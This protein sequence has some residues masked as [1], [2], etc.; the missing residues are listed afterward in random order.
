MSLAI[1]AE[2]NARLL[3]DLRDRLGAK[4]F[5][6]ISNFFEVGVNW[7]CP[8]C[9]RSKPEI[10]RLD[11][12]SDLL[13]S[14][15]LHHDHFD[16]CVC[17]H[18]DLR[19]VADWSVPRAIEESLV[20]FSAT[21]IC[22]DC[23]VAEPAAKQMVEAPAAFSFAPYEIAGFITVTANAP[24]AVDADRAREVYEA[25]RPSMK[26]LAARLRAIAKANETQGEAWEPA[27]NA[28]WRVLQN[29]RRKMKDAAE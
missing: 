7:R 5:G 16:A 4:K 22:S 28:A 12:N 8:C 17:E 11:K 14:L 1:S 24:H 6:S 3:V 25:A 2:D 21:L 20:R 10:A 27:A 9:Y 13:C 18:L 15:V 26:V 23:N 29:V 19:D